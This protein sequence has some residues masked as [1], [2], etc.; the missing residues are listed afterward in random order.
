MTLLSDITPCQPMLRAL[1]LRDSAVRR[2][3]GALGAA[4]QLRRGR[5]AWAA[6]QG[7]LLLVR[8]AG[9]RDPLPG[10]T[11]AAARIATVVGVAREGQTTIQEWSDAVRDNNTVYHYGIVPVS[12]GGLVGPLNP[13][14]VRTRV[15]DNSGNVLGLL[16]P[17]PGAVSAE[18]LT[19]NTPLVRWA[20]SSVGQQTPPASF[21]IYTGT[22][23][24]E[25]DFSVVVATVAYT[26][27][28]SMYSWLGPALTPGVTRYYAVR[29]V[30]AAG[31][32]SLIPQLGRGPAPSYTAVDRQR[33][34]RVVCPPATFVGGGGG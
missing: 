22:E 7:Y 17:A 34:P 18:L 16:P 32:L 23:S 5:T 28:V 14:Q 29:S 11:P 21:K 4:L 20:V 3:G 13:H 10:I 24:L 15:V 6:D 31:V 33:C 26:V 1:V 30:S 27:G 19:G 8:W 12:A 2:G 9:E 25:V